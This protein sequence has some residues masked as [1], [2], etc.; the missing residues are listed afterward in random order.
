MKY[1]I[2]AEGCLA[3]WMPEGCPQKAKFIGYGEGNSFAEA[4][5]NCIKKEWGEIAW[6]KYFRIQNGIPYAYMRLYDNEIDARKQF[7]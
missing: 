5:S 6:K 3:P 2:W 4:A 7:G 1:E